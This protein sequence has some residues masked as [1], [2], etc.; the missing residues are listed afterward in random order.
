ME[1]GSASRRGPAYYWA[2]VGVFLSAD[3]D[4]ILGLLTRAD[5]FAVTD[6]QQ[7]DA[8]QDEIRIL[9]HTLA[10][11]SGTVFLEFYRVLLTRARQGMVIFVPPGDPADSTRKPEF[12]DET[13]EYLAGLGMSVL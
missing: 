6:R 7:V 9:R 4:A 13:Y 2:D 8:W 1:N 3:P 5:P 12:Y 10:G 11:S